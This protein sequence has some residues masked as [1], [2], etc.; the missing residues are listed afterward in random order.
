[1]RLL[2][3]LAAQQQQQ[4]Y[5]HCTLLVYYCPG[6]Q[7]ILY[8][9]WRRKDEAQAGRVSQTIYKEQTVPQQ[10]VDVQIALL[11]LL[12][13]CSLQH[14]DAI[15]TPY[16]LFFRRFRTA[17]LYLSSSFVPPP[18]FLT[19]NTTREM[20]RELQKKSVGLSPGNVNINKYI[21]GAG[22]QHE[23]Y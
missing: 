23:P 1:M 13:S 17:F 20:V 4:P 5:A 6:S 7:D 18:F 8:L 2:L 14:T 12:L 11:L 16:I 22:S 15:T 21:Y 19:D 9:Y 10:H 3:L